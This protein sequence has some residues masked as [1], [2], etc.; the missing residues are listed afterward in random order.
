MKGYRE[1]SRNR[2]RYMAEQIRDIARFRKNLLAV[3]EI[4]RVD[5]VVSELGW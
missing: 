3:I 1:S 4:E 5:G 2:E